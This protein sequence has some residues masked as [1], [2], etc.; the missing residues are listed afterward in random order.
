[1]ELGV[2]TFMDYTK[3]RALERVLLAIWQVCGSAK[4]FCPVEGMWHSL[5][6][7]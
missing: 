4:K 6:E 2:R 5:I 3:A 7:F 1:M